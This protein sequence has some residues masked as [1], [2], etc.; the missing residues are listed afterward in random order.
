MF[1]G[2]VGRCSEGGLGLHGVWY[3]KK[4]FFRWMIA[5]LARTE[6]GGGKTELCKSGWFLVC[7]LADTTCRLLTVV[8]GVQYLGLS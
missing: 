4:E 8:H 6:A 3:R 1:C 5:R 2:L 7:C